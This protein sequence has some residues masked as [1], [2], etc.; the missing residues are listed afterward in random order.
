MDTKFFLG[1][2]SR[3]SAISAWNRHACLFHLVLLWHWM[4]S[5]E[6]VEMWFGCSM[7]PGMIRRGSMAKS[8]FKVGHLISRV[9]MSEVT[10]CIATAIL[11]QS[12]ER[13]VPI[14]HL[15]MTNPS[16]NLCN[17]GGPHLARDTRFKRYI[18]SIH[19][20][21]SVA[22]KFRSRWSDLSLSPWHVIYCIE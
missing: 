8:L 3:Y 7:G 20:E 16:C 6:G 12:S 14:E 13:S 15:C 18:N 5:T 1:H 22:P 4:S 10:E 17:T 19:S 21:R 2:W 9:S 11:S